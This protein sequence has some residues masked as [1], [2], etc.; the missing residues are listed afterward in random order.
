MKLFDNLK[1]M[2]KMA[3]AAV[4]SVISGYL[5]RK[6]REMET[7]NKQFELEQT[8][9]VLME[10]VATSMREFGYSAEKAAD[11]LRTV[12]RELEKSEQKAQSSRESTNNWRK[13]HG[14]PMRRKIP[15]RRRR[16]R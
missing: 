4:T 2:A 10:D 6:I 12:L 14:L 7:W 5:T 8:E 1:R 16:K 9:T 3:D 11:A 15:S 13:M